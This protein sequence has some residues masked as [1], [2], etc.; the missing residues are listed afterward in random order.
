LPLVKGGEHKE[1]IIV[2]REP[3]EHPVNDQPEKIDQEKKEAESQALP[4][5]APLVSRLSTSRQAF[6][7]EIERGGQ[8]P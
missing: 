1:K 8:V 6:K 2:D 3:P 5:G 4:P 7:D